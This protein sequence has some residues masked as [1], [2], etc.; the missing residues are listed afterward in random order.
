MTSHIS[1]RADD[2]VQECLHQQRSFAM[3][4][5]AGSGKTT[6][7]VEALK[8]LLKLEGSR[9]LR[10]GQQ[11][12][13]ITYTNRAA[14]VISEK[15]CQN[16]LF[17]VSTLHSFLWS[18]I[19]HFPTSIRES[20][21][22]TVLPL[23]IAKQEMNDNG[24]QSKKAIDARAKIV[25]LKQALAQLDSVSDFHYGNDSLFSNY[26]KGEIG[27]DDLVYV[28]SDMIQTSRPLRRILGQNFPYILVDEAQDTSPE[29]VAAF[30]TLC[31]G[32]GLP[33]LGYF[34]DPMQQIYD[35]GMGNFAGPPGSRVITKDENFRSAPEVISLLNVF[36]SDVIQFAAGSNSLMQ[37]SVHITLVKAET[38]DAPRGRYSD[39]Q[40]QRA[41]L[42]LSEAIALW[43][44]AQR[45]D[46]KQLFLARRMIAR[47]LGFL[48]IHDLFDGPHASSRAKNAYEKGEHFLL[49]PLIETV[50]PLVKAYREGDSGAVMRVLSTYT[51]AFRP[52]G[53]YSKKSIR[54]VREIANEVT[55]TLAKL[56]ASSTLGNVLRYCRE[57]GV[58]QVSE[59]LASHLNRSPREEVFDEAKHMEDKADW[60]ADAFFNMHCVEIENYCNFLT[61]NTVYSTQHGVKGEQYDDVIVVFDD[62]EAAWN[63]YSFSKMM[64]PETAGESKDTQR[65]RSRKLAYVCFS[66]AVRNLR[67]L[68]FTPAPTAAAHELRAKRL[69][70]ESQISILDSTS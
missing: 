50:M 10:D 14:A 48:T 6:S 62:A 33:I 25:E 67:I 29:I 41:Q 13:C 9:M 63:N 31:A 39:V 37:G 26:F 59:L 44:W 40:L 30:N 19:Y 36:R 21:R 7:L 45:K 64:N 61:E 49:K 17:I 3:I 8:S 1:T 42:R 69:F 27:H 18:Q 24:G 16:P 5:G 12:V 54:E 53:L 43:G 15:L 52:S 56:L 11:V 60:L 51:V 55:S 66:R 65:E 57:N 46:A 58:I 20:L 28:A 2:E 35:N 4:A 68:L 70:H 47:R 38:P 23:H 22:R 32:D 34:G